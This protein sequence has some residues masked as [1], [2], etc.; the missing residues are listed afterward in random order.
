MGVQNWSLSKLL[1][2]EWNLEKFIATGTHSS[3]P[4]CAAIGGLCQVLAAGKGTF[5]TTAASPVLTYAPNRGDWGTMTHHEDL[6]EADRLIADCVDR[7]ARQR[8]M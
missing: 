2:W 4:L 8:Q 5:T 6:A 1:R 3:E 7:I